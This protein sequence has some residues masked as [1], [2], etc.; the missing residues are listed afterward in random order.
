MPVAVVNS[1]EIVHVDHQKTENGTAFDAGLQ[2]VLEAA[3]VGKAG[4][5]I[6]Q[7]NAFRFAQLI[8]VVVNLFRELVQGGLAVFRH[9]LDAGLQRRCTLHDRAADSRQIIQRRYRA[10]L[11]R[12]LADLVGILLIAPTDRVGRERNGADNLLHLALIV[13]VQAHR[14][15][16]PY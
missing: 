4:Q 3:A 11:A 14:E 7:G 9:L 6:E 13:L 10:E 16:G 15:V 2:L 12:K 8:P 5:R 1:F